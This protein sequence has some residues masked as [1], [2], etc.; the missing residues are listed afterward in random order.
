[1]PAPGLHS[2]RGA[3]VSLSALKAA[4]L[5]AVGLPGFSA[6]VRRFFARFR[7]KAPFGIPP[8]TETTEG[9]EKFQRQ[10]GGY[11]RTGRNPQYA[12]GGQPE[13]GPRRQF[14]R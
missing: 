11:S 7:A 5:P 9:R 6:L 2:A 1:M 4:H 3:A 12:A 10:Y 14:A 13:R 8:D